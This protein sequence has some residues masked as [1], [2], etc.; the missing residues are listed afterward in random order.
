M[1]KVLP[2]LAALA[3]AAAVTL[4]NA[5]PAVATGE[6]LGC[7]VTPS[8]TQPVLHPRICSDN[9][10]A[11]SYQAMF[12]L[13]DGSGTYSYSWSVPAAYAGNISSGC[14]QDATYCL[15]TNLAPLD[16]V[17]VSVTIGQNGVS[18]TLT[19]RANIGQWCGNQRCL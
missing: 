12:G 10:P 8:R 15:L 16:L 3:A 4:V 19:A 5:G 2:A 9:M 17:A 6:A 14:T 1:R 13:V 18:S 7:Y 11:D